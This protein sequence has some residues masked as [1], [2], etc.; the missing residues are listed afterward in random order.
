MDPLAHTLAG[1]TLGETGLK[2]TTALG[3]LTLMIGANLPDIDGVAMLWGRDAGLT[4][5]RGWTHGVLAMVILPLALAG[6]MHFIGK[7]RALHVGTAPPH[8]KFLLLLSVLSVWSHPFLDW[9][10]QYGVRLLMPFSDDW[11][12]GDALFIVDPWLW[13]MGGCSV[14]LAHSGNRK[15]GIAWL[16]LLAVAVAI[17]TQSKQAPAESKMIWCIGAGLMVFLRFRSVRPNPRHTAIVATATIVTYIG[18]MILGTRLAETQA[19]R[20]LERQGIIAEA[21]AAMPLPAQPFSRDVVIRV[22]T[23]YRFFT[24]RWAFEPRIKVAHPPISIGEKSAVVRAALADPAIAGAAHWLRF[25]AF[26]EM[27]TDFGYR[28]TI[29]DV[30]YSRSGISS[31]GVVTVDLNRKLEPIVYPQ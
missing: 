20:Y 2:R 31:I 18:T 3:G 27:T 11:F 26:E 21:I 1:A 29:R 7:R 22:G 16:I 5:R 9:L 4:Y 17:V 12:Y 24:L 6:V 13:L 23:Q 25:P 14:A 19:R 15:T 8:F 28:V 10:N 30:R